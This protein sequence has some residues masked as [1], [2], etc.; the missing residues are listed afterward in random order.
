MLYGFV[1]VFVDSM[2]TWETLDNVNLVPYIFFDSIIHVRHVVWVKVAQYWDCLQLLRAQ[3]HG[4]AYRRILRL[5][6]RFPAYK[7]SAEFLR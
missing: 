6:S 1:F 2:F 5:L 3:F 4:S 7:A